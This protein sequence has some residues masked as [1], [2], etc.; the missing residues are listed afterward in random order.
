M[1]LRRR[2]EE[3]TNLSFLDVIA[4]GFGAIVL[5]LMITKI[6][7]PIVLEQ[8]TQNLDGIVADLQKQLFA[9]RG[10]TTILNRDL[11]VKQE[12]LSE[13]REKIARLQGDLN[14]IKGQ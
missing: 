9:I 11:T 5:L 3:D 7:E 2:G 13:H 8:A 10:E 6:A 1:K 14:T 12:Q 4:C